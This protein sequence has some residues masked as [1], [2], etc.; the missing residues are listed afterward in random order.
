MKLIFYLFTKF[1]NKMH[2]LILNVDQRLLVEKIQIIK[3]ACQSNQ[4]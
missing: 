1:L 2:I 3:T 4:K